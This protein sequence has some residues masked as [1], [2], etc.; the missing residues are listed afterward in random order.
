[1]SGRKTFSGKDHLRI[2]GIRTSPW[3]VIGSVLILMIIV[4]ILAVHNYDREKRYMSR[5][6][7]EKGAALI[8]AVEA[9]ARTGMM[10]TNWGGTQVQALIEQAAQMPD[11]RFLAVVNKDGVILAHSDPHRVGSRFDPGD[12]LNPPASASETRWRI[13]Q[14]SKHDRIFEVYKYFKPVSAKDFRMPGCSDPTGG[15]Q[16]NTMCSESDWC[17]PADLDNSEHIIFAGLDAGPFEDAR[18]EDIRNTL[19]ISG[20][21]VV[22]GWAGFIS[23]FWMQNYRSARQSLQDTRALA[24]EIVRSLPVGLLV[25]DEEGK[26]SFFN[27]AAEKITGLNLKAAPG[28][29]PET[30]L[31]SAICE[32]RPVLSSGQSVTEKEMDCEFS[33]GRR[34]PLSISASPIVNEAGRFVGQVFILRDLEEVRRLQN[35]I[36]RKDKLAAIGSL[37]AGVAHEIRNP[38]SS[39]KGIAAYFKGKFSEDSQDTEAADVLIHEADRLN[40]VVGEL[41]EF[42]RPAALNI[43]E[44]D[45]NEL[46]N[47]SIRLVRQ[48]AAAMGIRIGL[49][50]AYGP[51]MAWMDPDRFLQCCLN[52]HLNALQAMEKGGRLMVSSER[53]ATGDV[54]IV[55]GD[56]GTGIRPEDLSRIFDPFFTTKARGTGLGL[57]I[58]RN[59]IEE[60][61]GQIAVDSVAGR[62]TT[63]TVTIPQKEA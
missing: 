32:L 6:L 36:R 42:A 5:I 62:G 38:L 30:V 28:N 26:I 61:H 4:L 20:V 45:V 16:T 24:G 34:V 27:P 25:T 22:L 55:I 51:L 17:S 56:T 57:A 43:R 3:V 54:R 21:L 18:R 41:L 10:G 47:H 19:I 8:M 59:V 35:E 58:V 44:T 52:L 48:E 31:P 46:L 9:G 11:V 15:N 2:G 40:R 1:M 33:P 39:I 37:A 53:V 12:S 23:L 7:T 13:V 49:N 14:N 60:H 63:F 50:L 29:D